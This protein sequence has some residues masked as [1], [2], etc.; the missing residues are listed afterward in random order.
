MNAAN[1]AWNSAPH[2]QPLSPAGKYRGEGSQAISGSLSGGR[3]FVVLPGDVT[4]ASCD[5]IADSLPCVGE[6][7]DRDGRHLKR[8]ELPASGASES[9]GACRELLRVHWSPREASHAV[10]TN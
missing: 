1:V 10:C 3:P 2:P 4:R 9:D 5:V 6:W 8:F 7:V